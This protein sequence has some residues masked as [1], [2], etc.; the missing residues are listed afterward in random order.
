MYLAAQKCK[1]F[2]SSEVIHSII[3][4]YSECI[5]PGKQA[6]LYFHLDFTWTYLQSNTVN[7]GSVLLHPILILTL[8]SS[9]IPNLAM[10]YF[11]PW[12]SSAFHYSSRKVQDFFFP[13]PIFWHGRTVRNIGAHRTVWLPELTWGICMEK[14]LGGGERRGTCQGSKNWLFEFHETM[15]KLLTQNSITEPKNH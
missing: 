3:C 5:I 4:I 2:T 11:I 7:K 8:P 9:H 6:A 1:I 12:A 10:P 14:K 15:L 13:W